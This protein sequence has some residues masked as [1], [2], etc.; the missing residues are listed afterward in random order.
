MQFSN[1]NYLFLIYMPTALLIV[2]ILFNLS[3]CLSDNDKEVASNSDTALLKV[4][5]V[6][7]KK[8]AQGKRDLGQGETLNMRIAEPD[9]DRN[10]V[11][12]EIKLK[13]RKDSALDF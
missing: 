1:K 7:D 6:K 3:G 10:M 9:F 4:M 12:P 5:G 8:T 11:E 13:K 2:F